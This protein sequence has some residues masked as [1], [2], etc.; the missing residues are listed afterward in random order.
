L[1]RR[2][3]SCSGDHPCKR[4]GEEGIYCDYNVIDGRTTRKQNTQRETPPT[5]ASV[6]S[7]GT[8]NTTDWASGAS[9]SLPVGPPGPQQQ[10]TEAGG[11]MN[12]SSDIS[13]NS[14]EPGIIYEYH[15][16]H[17]GPASGLAFLQE[18]VQ[19]IEHTHESPRQVNVER[20]VVASASIFT[21]GDMPTI[22][23]IETRLEMP[24]Q[25]KS[26]KMLSRY[27]DFA[28]PTYRFFHRPSVERWATE[29]IHGSSA[30]SQQDIRSL[31]LAP[32][33]QAAVFLIWAQALEYNDAKSPNTTTRLARRIG[34]I[35][36]S[37]ISKANHSTRRQDSSLIMSQDLQ[38]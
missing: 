11:F 34:S 22:S 24:S 25:E 32:A 3:T 7:V 4:C 10:F 2:K 18:A 17:T 31:A 19:R 6:A 1:A 33:K 14:L 20:P 15:E 21:S 12:R 37:L 8:A 27:F 5:D 13:R 9:S 23:S 36:C 29:I 30:E 28:T 16:Q 38:D 35:Y 26:D